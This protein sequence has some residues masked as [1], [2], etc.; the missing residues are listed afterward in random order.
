MSQELNAPKMPTG[1]Y[2]ELS[3]NPN[4]EGL[5]LKDGGRGTPV[6]VNTEP[7]QANTNTITVNEVK[8]L[9][10]EGIDHFEKEEGGV[11]EEELQ[12]AL[13]VK[14]DK[15]G[16]LPYFEVAATTTIHDFVTAN[17][18]NGKPVI[19]KIGTDGYTVFGKILNIGGN[20]YTYELES[21]GGIDR[22]ADTGVDGTTR[23]FEEA[24]AYNRNKPYLL[25]SEARIFYAEVVNI[26]EGYELTDEL[27]ATFKTGN[28]LKVNQMPFVINK[29]E[30]T[31]EGAYKGITGTA[32]SGI[33]ANSITVASIDWRT[34]GV[35]YTEL[36]IT[37]TTLTIPSAE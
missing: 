17:G 14:A 30:T 33:T 26:Q 32:V 12:E 13:K 23:T 34:V 35:G 27:W 31:G 18:V 9:I 16:S 10:R 3:P 5:K 37:T 6:V 24:T 21:L 4:S 28:I 11:T 20:Y 29:I 25:T 2:P 8:R 36:E 1:T 15:V 7:R 22:W 19:I